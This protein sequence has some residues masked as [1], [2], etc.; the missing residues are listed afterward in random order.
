VTAP[1]G[2]KTTVTAGELRR[3]NVML[4]E[5]SLRAIDAE[6]ELLRQRGRASASRSAVLRRL[7]RAHLCPPR[8]S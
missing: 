7:V 1:R 3:T 2:G 5:F 8:N 6:V 4:D